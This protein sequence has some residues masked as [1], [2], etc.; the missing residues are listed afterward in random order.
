MFGNLIGQLQSLRNVK[1]PTAF[2]QQL[3][4]TLGS[5]LAQ[6]EAAL[7]HRGPITADMTPPAIHNQEIF[8]QDTLTTIG[9]DQRFLVDGIPCADIP[10]AI[11]AIN[12]DGE[13]FGNDFN[14]VNMGLA[15]LICGPSLFKGNV[16]ID[17]TV[18][19]NGFDV[20]TD[21][22]VKVSA[23]ETESEDERGEYLS[24]QFSLV[25]TL[26]AQEF[27]SEDLQIELDHRDNTWAPGDLAV[28]DED[29]D[30][31]L[32]VS[33]LDQYSSGE[34]KI[35]AV[36]G[37][38]I[39]RLM[40]WRV[41]NRGLGEP[42][43]TTISALL[44]SATELK[45]SAKTLVAG[46]NITLTPTADTLEIAGSSGSSSLNVSDACKSATTRQTS[47]SSVTALTFSRE[48]G[49]VLY[50]DPAS[51]A[52]PVVHLG[53]D[54]DWMVPIQFRSSDAPNGQRWTR[55]PV[56]NSIHLGGMND[57]DASP[58]TT[59]GSVILYSTA[60]D[61][62]RLVKGPVAD[63]PPNHQWLLLSDSPLAVAGDVLYAAGVNTEVN[64]QDILW[65]Y[66][67]GAHRFG[68]VEIHG[69][70]GTAYK[71]HVN[72]AGQVY[73]IEAD[74]VEQLVDVTSDA[75]TMPNVPATYSYDF[76]NGWQSMTEPP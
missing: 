38:V 18:I 49:L 62:L 39:P 64:T 25:N 54:K 22:L 56:V 20:N 11:R 14:R 33:D 58:N 8:P 73:S 72:R 13:L 66:S 45:V 59:A 44:D 3:V 32:D 35:L 10:A 34:R 12:R 43:L 21:E 7:E 30:P 29:L 41:E 37:E 52:T 4:D 70:D 31:F 5:V 40:A 27:A 9:I 65:Q 47:F 28:G 50:E 57:N 42:L 6:C 24:D 55:T 46:S 61:T 15:L 48:A 69:Q 71:I 75:F 1:D 60:P 17:G 19:V 51:A 23:T 16:R 76:C 67:G 63:S 53:I 68:Q 26:G 74:S 36:G 2:Q